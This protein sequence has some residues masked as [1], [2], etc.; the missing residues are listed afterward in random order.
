MCDYPNF[1]TDEA[2]VFII[3]DQRSVR[4]ALVE[5]FASAEMKALAFESAS[6]FLGREAFDGDGC[7]FLDLN[8]PDINGLELQ[9]RL[10]EA[11]NKLPVIFMTGSRDILSSVAAMKAGAMDLLL[12]PFSDSAVIAA[13]HEAMEKAARLRTRDTVRSKVAV[14]MK[15]LTP[16]QKEVF[17]YVVQ[18]L[19]NKQIAHE[20]NISETM[21]KVHRGRMMKKMRSNSVADLVRKSILFEQRPEYHS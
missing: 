21:V 3:D 2:I 20:M 4:E 18:G 1:T 7:I 15:A 6:S 12:K 9:R 19:M 17:D 8:L 16:R 10:A 13:A 11:G 5:L 14:C